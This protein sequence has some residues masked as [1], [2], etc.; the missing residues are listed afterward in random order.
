[1]FTE[2]YDVTYPIASGGVISTDGQYAGVC[3]RVT[4]IPGYLGF[5]TR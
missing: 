4:A 5:T 1:M 3:I 2:K